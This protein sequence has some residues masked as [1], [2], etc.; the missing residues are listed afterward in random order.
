MVGGC[1]LQS[2]FK[3]AARLGDVDAQQE[4][5]FCYANG[6]GCKKDL[7]EAAKWYRAAVSIWSSFCVRFPFLIV[8]PPSSGRTRRLDRR[9]GM[10]LQAKVRRGHKFPEGEREGKGSIQKPAQSLAP[11]TC[12]E[13]D[14]QWHAGREHP[15]RTAE[16]EE[17]ESET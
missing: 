12:R 1:D 9:S 3:V 4:L 16:I 14:L 11:P 15:R 6:K 17:A 7:K 10:D 2:Y 13:L 8:P 5:G